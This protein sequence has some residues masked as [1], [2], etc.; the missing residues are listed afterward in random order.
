MAFTVDLRRRNVVHVHVEGV[1]CYEAN[2]ADFEVEFPHQVEQQHVEHI[3][4]SLELGIAIAAQ[5]SPQGELG[6][7]ATEWPGP[8]DEDQTSPQLVQPLQKLGTENFTE[9]EQEEEIAT[10]MERNPT[11]RTFLYSSIR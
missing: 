6:W 4:R 7:D 10:S 9:L 3:C 8:G 2:I 1:G 5:T 11:T